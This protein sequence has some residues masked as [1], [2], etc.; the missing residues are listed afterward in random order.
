MCA[1]IRTVNALHGVANPGLPNIA[2]ELTKIIRSKDILEEPLWVKLARNLATC[3]MVLLN[4]FISYM[5]KGEGVVLEV[6]SI[7]SYYL[8]QQDKYINC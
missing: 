8:L 2:Q 5:G 4:I 7:F 1:W 3:V 6:I